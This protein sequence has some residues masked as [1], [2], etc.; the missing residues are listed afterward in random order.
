MVN[1]KH[2]FGVL[3]KLLV[4]NSVFIVIGVLF[5]VE[6]FKSYPLSGQ[7]GYSGLLWSGGMNNILYG[8]CLM[9]HWSTKR[10]FDSVFM[11]LSLSLLLMGQKSAVL[12]LTLILFFVVNQSVFIKTLFLAEL[13]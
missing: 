7:W 1:E 9:Y 12:Y 11:L 2:F 6:I 8:I 4:F 13:L 5:S 10:K 3:K